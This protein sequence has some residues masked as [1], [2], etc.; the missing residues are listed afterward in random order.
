MP[1]DGHRLALPVLCAVLIGLSLIAC[2]RREEPA[3][4]AASSIAETPPVREAK[5]LRVVNQR[6]TSFLVLHIADKEGYFREQGLNVE[7]VEART[8]LDVLPAVAS[9]EIQVY[10]GTVNAAL[11]N[12]VARGSK[13]RI[14]ADKGHVGADDKYVAVM[15]RKELVDEGKLDAPGGLRGLRVTRTANSPIQYYLEAFLKQKGV[16]PDDVEPVVMPNPM[17]M[18]ALLNNATDLSSTSEPWVTRMLKTGK[19][20]MWDSADHVMPGLQFSII[21]YS[22]SMLGERRDE[23][24]RFMIAYLKAVRDLNQGK[25]AKNVQ[26][27][28][29]FTGLEPELVREMHWPNMRSD[30]SLNL[31]SLRDFNAWAVKRGLVDRL[32]ADEEFWD[33][34]F[35]EEANSAL[36]AM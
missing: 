5:P 24:R 32:L 26:Y 11:I 27:M 16:S 12:A 13:L 7:F 8:G 6:F 28:A 4:A 20:V 18:E 15:T 2:S 34:R 21:A 25:T 35:I 10:A 29:E 17:V 22:P 23:G 36:A 31:Q 33:L 14:V 9:D 30:G 3:P 1:H 19:L